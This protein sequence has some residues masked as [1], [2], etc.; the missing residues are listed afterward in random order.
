M[1]TRQLLTCFT[2]LML[3]ATLIEPVSAGCLGRLFGRRDAYVAQSPAVPAPYVAQYAPSQVILPSNPRDLPLVP[4]QQN[5]VYQAQRPAYGQQTPI[6]INNQ[7]IYANNPS[8]YTGRPVIAGSA[9]AAPI[10]SQPTLIGPGN[11]QTSYSVPIVTPAPR[12]TS[13]VPLASTM[14][15]NVAV[16]API[17]T[18]ETYQANYAQAPI[19]PA[20]ITAPAPIT[21]TPPSALS[22]APVAPLYVTPQ[23]QP[24]QRGGL[25]RFFGSI[26]GTNYRSSYYRA[27]ITYYRPVTTVDPVTGTTV[28]V[29]RPCTSY[30]QR[31]QRT[32]YVTIQRPLQQPAPCPA[33]AACAPNGCSTTIYSTP[34]Y[35]APAYGTPAPLGAVTSPPTYGQG[36]IGQ[37]G[38]MMQPGVHSVSPI[39]STAP[40]Y[41][42]ATSPSNAYPPAGQGGGGDL[43]PVDRPALPAAPLSNRPPV[44]SSPAPSATNPAAAPAPSPAATQPPA[45]QPDAAPNAKPS[46][47]YWDLK[48]AAN[49]TVQQSRPPQQPLPDP[50]SI[51]SQSPVSAAN[52]VAPIRAPEDYRSPFDNQTRAPIPRTQ[53]PALLPSTQPNDRLQAPPLLPR[54]QSSPADKWSRPF[55]SDDANVTS[56]STPVS[57]HVRDAAMTHNR[58]FQPAPIEQKRPYR[59]NLGWEPIR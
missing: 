31:L 9:A 27:P 34:A 6:F 22:A 26:L 36:T 5:G 20:P 56:V 50:T 37:V 57:V 41:P 54:R 32:P 23:P 12:A 33:P 47:S 19:T 53:S 7:P 43:A 1:L 4:R 45:P 59:D 52:G 21:G 35:S 48:D 29:Q 18:S 15:G 44:G 10:M 13:N 40:G 55:N 24:Q 17:I 14:R 2:T 49:S 58:K 28:T 16:T 51:T 39:P 46:E 30:V 42:P 38:G 25:S 8:V 3:G 11:V